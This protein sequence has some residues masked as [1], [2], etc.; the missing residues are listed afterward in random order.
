MILGVEGKGEGR[1]GVGHSVHGRLQPVLQE[2]LDILQGT[3][4]GTRRLKLPLACSSMGA[5]STPVCTPC[6]AAPPLLVVRARE[7]A[8][9]WCP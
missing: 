8:A 9:S 4:A 7:G 1:T 2:E 6:A 5:V 3:I